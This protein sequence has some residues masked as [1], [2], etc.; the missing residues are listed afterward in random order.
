MALLTWR[1]RPKE[2]YGLPGFEG[3]RIGAVRRNETGKASDNRWR[4]GSN[5]RN[6]NAAGSLQCDLWAGPGAGLAA[7]QTLAIYPVSGWWKTR[8]P[9]KRYNSQARYALIMTLKS[10]DENVDLHAEIDS[11][12]DLRISQDIDEKS[13]TF[14]EAVVPIES[15]AG[16]SRSRDEEDPRRSQSNPQ[17]QLGVRSDLLG[18]SDRVRCHFEGRLSSIATRTRC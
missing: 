11:V 7:R 9:K 10:L 4:F 3:V 16:R 15:R 18:Q 17:S 5:S 1:C 2:L 12:I 6:K 14:I 13:A 8:A